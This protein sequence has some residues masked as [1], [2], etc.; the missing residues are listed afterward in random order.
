MADNTTLNS[1]S[2]GDVIRTD[3]IS[4]VKFPTSKITIGGDGTDG[5]FVATDNP[6]PVQLR[7]SA[8]AELGTNAAPVQVGDG[9]A[10][11][12]VD[13]GNGSLT[14]DTPDGSNAALGAK[15]DAAASSD[16]GTFSLIALVKRLLEKLTA[17]LTIGAALPAGD[18]NIGNVDVATQ[19]ARVRTTDTMSAADTTDAVMSGTTALTPKFAVIS[20]STL[21]N[22]EIV[23][24][25][26]DKKIRVLAYTLIANGDLT[27]TWKSAATAL[28]GAMPLTQYSGLTPP[29]CKLG[30]FETA[31][32]EALNLDMSAAVQVSGHL[33][34]VEV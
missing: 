4:G 31:T 22:N 21:A 17:G 25:V 12:S 26:A 16:A 27:V 24:A 13:D 23:A 5:G 29:Y 3:D 10:T 34:Y 15:A 6:L 28:S 9:G 7:S 1:G 14:T 18:N 19:P 30:H 32:G 8:G 11:L 2:G 33:V 20:E